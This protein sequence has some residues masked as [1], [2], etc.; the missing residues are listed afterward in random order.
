MCDYYKVASQGT[1]YIGTRWAFIDGRFGENS[2]HVS[3][4][5]IGLGLPID[6]ATFI[7]SNHAVFLVYAKGIDSIR[8]LLE[9]LNDKRGLL[10]DGSK[11]YYIYI[12]SYVTVTW[13]GIGY[14][15]QDEKPD[16]ETLG[17]PYSRIREKFKPIPKSGIGLGIHKQLWNMENASSY[18]TTLKTVKTTLH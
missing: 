5:W 10:Q 3:L 12:E 6:Y 8:Q 2:I 7:Q 14:I 17:T 4:Q 15:I 9:F 18:P 1:L 11:D 13:R 16:A